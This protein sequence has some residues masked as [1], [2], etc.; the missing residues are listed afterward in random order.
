MYFTVSC[1]RWPWGSFLCE[2]TLCHLKLI[3]RNGSKLFL[4]KL[5][6][7]AI[8]EH[9]Y[10]K[11]RR[12]ITKMLHLPSEHSTV[13]AI[14]A[15]SQRGY[16]E[17]N[18][19]DDLVQDCSISRALAM[20]IL[21]SCSKQD[22]WVSHW[23]QPANSQG[24]CAHNIIEKFENYLSPDFNSNQSIR[25]KFAHLTTAWPPW[26]Q[27]PLWHI[28]DTRIICCKI[29]FS[30]LLGLLTFIFGVNSELVLVN[31]PLCCE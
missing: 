22:Q 9:L 20:E 13:I 19:F 5:I 27:Y 6:N 29:D 4:Y 26:G 8:R 7:C 10:N 12:I 31:N 23:D 3:K 30:M 11:I 17:W 15:R 21:Q 28:S 18:H 25:S 1:P 24:I 16:T 2:S 14:V